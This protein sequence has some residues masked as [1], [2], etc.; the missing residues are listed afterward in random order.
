[1]CKLFDLR[2]K[3]LIDANTKNAAKKYHGL[4]LRSLVQRW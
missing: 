4:T 2:A 3:A 1:M